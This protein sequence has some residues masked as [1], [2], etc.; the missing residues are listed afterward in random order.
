MWRLKRVSPGYCAS[1]GMVILTSVCPNHAVADVAHA[2]CQ[3]DARFAPDG[4]IVELGSK[5]FRICGPDGAGFPYRLDPSEGAP[6]IKI[7]PRSLIARQIEAATSAPKFLWGQMTFEVGFFDKALENSK[8]FKEVELGDI[9]FGNA[10]YALF[11]DDWIMKNH[12]GAVRKGNLPRTTFFVFERPDGSEIPSHFMSCSGDPTAMPRSKYDCFIYLRYR[13][14]RDFY[15][16]H[17]L[18]WSPTFEGEP[19]DFERIPDLVRAVHTLFEVSDVTEKLETLKHIPVV[20]A[21]D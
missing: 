5:S 19:M 8:L 13:E 12:Q 16:D 9:T 11:S 10:R 3:S 14:S 6:F 4:R 20:R 2:F 17:R 21:S 15:I 18:I 7:S 1:L